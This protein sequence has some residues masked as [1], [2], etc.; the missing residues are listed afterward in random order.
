MAGLDLLH[1]PYRGAAPALTDV[2]AGRVTL[3]FSSLGLAL[4]LIRD[5]KLRAIG[6]TSKARMP[7]LPDCP[8]LSEGP[9]LAGYELLN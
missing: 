8:F 1:V 2:T 7:Q 4:P 9:D 5:G 3:N 6:V